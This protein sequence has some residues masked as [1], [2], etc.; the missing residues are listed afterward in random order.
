MLHLKFKKNYFFSRWKN[1]KK[2]APQPLTEIVAHQYGTFRTMGKQLC[3]WTQRP[4]ESLIQHR[5]GTSFLVKDIVVVLI[6]CKIGK[7]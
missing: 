1:Y 6:G 5:N 3:P 4:Y 2:N 7:H